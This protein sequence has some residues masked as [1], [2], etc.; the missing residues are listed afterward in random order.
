MSALSFKINA[1]T[2]KLNSFIASLKR[3]K[4]V[5]ADIPSGTKEFDVINR[6]IAE[7]EARVEQTMKRI[8]Q[9][10]NQA[11]KTVSQP[12]AASPAAP[13]SVG[14]ASG[15]QAVN[16]ETEAWRGL[17]EELKTASDAKSKAMIELRQYQ[18]EVS[19]LKAV[20]A[21]LNKEELQN[22]QLSSKKRG[23]LLSAST[24]I[25]EYKQQISRLRREL[26][27]QIKLEQAA[28]G[29]MD[30]MSQALSRMRIVYRSL[31]KEERESTLGQNLLKNIQTLDTKIKELDAS[32]GN[33]Q[34]NVDNYAS[35]WNG[36][37]FSIQQVARELPSLAVSPQT[38]FLAISNN[39]PILA[40]QLALTKQR[41]QE[42]KNAGQSFTPVWKQVLSSIISWQTALV[43]GITVLTLYG[44][45][46]TG[47]VG[48]L[49]KGKKA[50][51]AAKVA[52]EQFHE[53]LSGGNIDAQGEI[54]KLEQL[55]KAAT[56]LSNTQKER[57]EAV[58]K[59]QD[60]YP[61]YFSN[62]SN[63][64]IMLGDAI[65]AYN[66]LRDAIIRTAEA[67]AAEER[68]KENAGYRIILS[69]AKAWERYSAA[70]HEIEPLTLQYADAQRRMKEYKGTSIF[71]QA[72]REAQQ[73]EQIYNVLEK[74]LSTL[75]DEIFDDLKKTKRG[76]ELVEIIEEVYNGNLQA[77]IQSMDAMDEK[78][79]RAAKPLYTTKS[80]EERNKE[81]KATQKEQE[82][83]A[84]EQEKSIKNLEKKLQQLRDEALQAE[85]N[86]MKEGSAKIIAQINFDYKKREQAITNAEN[87]LRKKQGGTLN[88]EQQK[89]VSNARSTYLS[90]YILAI[91]SAI[92][93]QMNKE[94]QAQNEY[95]AEYGDYQQKRLA[96]TELYAAKIAQ[97]ETSW[98]KKSAEAERNKAL[99]ELDLS[100]L[101]KTTLWTRLFKDSETMATA[102]I[103]KIIADTESLLQ[104][105]DKAKN[106]NGDETILAALGLTKEQVD[107]VAAEPEKLKPI[108][109]ALKGKID[110][111]N[112]RDPFG[113]LIKGFKDLT[114][115]GEDADK[116]T[117][118]VNKIISG[119]KGASTLIG[120][121]GDTMSE[122]GEAIG[123]DFVA[124][125]GESLN[126]LSD[127]I[128][129]AVSG[130][131]AG[132][133]IGGPAGAAVGAGIGIV[134]S[135]FSVASAAA[136]R[137]HEALTAIKNA[138]IAQQ[139]EYNLLLLE[140][141]L[142]YEKGTTIF[143]TD[144]YAKAANAVDVYKQ[145]VQ[146]LE[147]ALS[148]VANIDIVTGHKK[149][150]L[151]GWGK[152]KDLYSDILKVYPELISSNGEFNRELAETILNTRKMSEA[153]KNALQNAIDLYDQMEDALASVS[154]YLSGI[155]GNLGNTITDALVNAAESGTDAF[156]AL[157]DS[158]GDM[159]RTLAKQMIY[160]VSIAPLVEKAQ[161]DMLEW[162]KKEDIS[163]TE[164]TK[165][166]I[167]VLKNLVN[168]A[169]AQQ[170]QV[171]ELLE[172]VNQAAQENGFDISETPTQSGTARG[173]QVASQDEVA[174]QNGR[175]TDIQGK[176][177]DIRAY[178][179]DE[180]ISIISLI[181]SVA[182]IQVAVV[183]N[184]QINNE[185]LQYAVRTY[186]EVA[187]INASTRAINRTLTDI[188]EDITAIKRKTMDL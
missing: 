122:L 177:S 164:R 20:V 92:G 83:A 166:M 15:A 28:T 71:S 178:V 86:S 76:D 128:N 169:V 39:L 157:S 34:R 119:F 111:L 186:I 10:Q 40:D 108:L 120:D 147:N 165:G 27:N 74:K 188:K 153:N 3:L 11:A 46:I 116:Q 172:A 141:N 19:R 8:A 87:E 137:H 138:E 72:A 168:D 32:I 43:A 112:K 96:I 163:E 144:Q 25:E 129:N 152:G 183:Q 91:S 61:A 52:T 173:Y 31:N 60:L 100:M 77:F 36:L 115:A 85:I 113:Q 104:Y 126:L 167:S 160:S 65:T 161:N 105:I 102:S 16:A 133:A 84:S 151:F 110:A 154:D 94:R 117:E 107:A 29:S 9:M 53:T 179:M 114:E 54:V 134:T 68:I 69:E 106:G 35:S 145:S 14:S 99:K 30:E 13:S 80:P 135:L 26:A 24:S 175:L 7:M 98:A 4:E 124:G 125:F 136:K 51:D 88:P 56:D 55:Y 21:A 73:I 45:E 184:V 82:K 93:T 78:L 37:S 140:Q 171:N 101:K 70:L 103:K 121:I 95:L 123:S 150:G 97:A 162:A 89:L 18:N 33:H 149:T 58:K 6:K 142:E 118:A 174:E 67:K 2:D 22:G 139:R 38:F 143:G 5:L 170:G 79:A 156:A 49:F 159:I 146:S 81:Y 185:L 47:W 158:V 1:E 187:E 148:D 176:L 66:D 41:V 75:Q 59:L 23:Q 48:S 130:A 90:Q 50:V 181:S 127:T 180:T 109:D 12:T 57:A 63:E 131:Q 42:L 17:L 44:K 182:T 155:F 64:Q 62:M 132:M